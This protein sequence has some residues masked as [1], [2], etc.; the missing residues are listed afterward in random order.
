LHRDQTVWRSAKQPEQHLTTKLATPGDIKRLT[1]LK[2]Q[3]QTTEFWLEACLWNKLCF[4]VETR[5]RVAGGHVLQAIITFWLHVHR[6]VYIRWEHISRLAGQVARNIQDRRNVR[7][8][9]NWFF[10]WNSSS[11]SHRLLDLDRGAA[12][13]IV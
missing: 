6:R 5:V 11:F 2:S 8:G 7:K 1:C 9:R 4:T 13:A 12:R 3:R 10:G